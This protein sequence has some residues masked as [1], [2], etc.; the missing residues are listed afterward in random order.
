MDYWEILR[1]LHVERQ[2]L[3]R[4]IAVLQAIDPDSARLPRRGRKSMPVAERRIVAERMR[5]YW[6]KR[7]SSISAQA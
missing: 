6:E 7:K 2:R 5:A 3:D 4:A 1:E